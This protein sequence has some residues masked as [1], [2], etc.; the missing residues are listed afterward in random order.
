MRRPELDDYKDEIHHPNGSIEDVWHHGDYSNDL[1]KYVDY[2]EE[3][4]LLTR[5]TSMMNSISQDDLVGYLETHYE[6]SVMLN[7]LSSGSI[8]SPENLMKYRE[9][10]G[11][12]G[13]WELAKEIT[14]DFELLHRNAQWDG[15]WLETLEEYVHLRIRNI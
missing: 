7:D 15:D 1:E 12:G 9:L 3:R 11:T 5:N 13:M 8:Y 14:D 6:V 2:L 4:S 10:H